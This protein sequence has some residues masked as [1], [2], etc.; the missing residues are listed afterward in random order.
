ML[1]EQVGKDN[2]RKR[3]FE[4]SSESFRYLAHTRLGPGQMLALFQAN[5]A[6]CACVRRH[7]GHDACRR[8]A[9]AV[10]D[11]EPGTQRRFQ[12]QELFARKR[13]YAVPAGPSLVR[14]LRNLDYKE[15]VAKQ[16]CNRV[17]VNDPFSLNTLD[18]AH[19]VGNV[20]A[21]SIGHQALLVR[22][23]GKRPRGERLTYPKSREESRQRVCPRRI[24]TK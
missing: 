5:V 14:I 19:A 12:N 7:N 18:S 10:R 16:I 15:P 8:E 1:Q 21:I 22:E 23:L 6:K 9:A 4:T 17:C 3:S 20:L 2:L 24:R 11:E 13:H